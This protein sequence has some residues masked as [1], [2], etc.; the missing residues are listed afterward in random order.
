MSTSAGMG[1][2]AMMH[3]TQPPS[4]EQLV[5]K[6]D[7]DGDGAL[8]ASEVKGPL[9]DQF[10]QTDNNGNGLIST[11]ELEQGLEVL[12]A[13][14]RESIMGMMSQ[15]HQGM[16][17]IRK[18]PSS[19]QVMKQM[20]QDGDGAINSAEAQGPIAKQFKV[21]DQ[22]GD[23]KVSEKELNQRLEEFRHQMTEN[24]DRMMMKYQSMVNSRYASFMNPLSE[25]DNRP[26]VLAPLDPDMTV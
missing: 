14:K 8:S 19:E 18:P 6:M 13:E 12:R 23:G 1:R 26:V 16:E 20:D 5:E 3:G 2:M 4:A 24:Q 9:A 22:D 25:A 10:S 7:Q 15:F 11:K 17:N 21:A